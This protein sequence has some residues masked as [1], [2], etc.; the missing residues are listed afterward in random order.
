MPFAGS[1]TAS[2][3]Y[4]AQAGG[5]A[6]VPLR[7]FGGKLR[8]AHFTYTHTAGAGVGE[9][10]LVKLPAGKKKILNLLSH[11]RTS[12]M[13]ATADGDVGYRAYTNTVGVAVVA[14]PNA[15]GDGLDVATGGDL[16]LPL[17]AVGYLDLDS[18]DEVTIFVDINTA[19]IEDTDTIDG[20]IVYIH[21]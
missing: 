17:P 13:V 8:I 7:D 19:N 20:Y 14:D 5:S 16:G 1:P 15:L 3:T 21:S 12:A 2:A 9:I 6:K 18:S 4:L 11:F 10:N